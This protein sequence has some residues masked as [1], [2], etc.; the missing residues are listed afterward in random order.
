MNND[1]DE[2]EDPLDAFMAGIENQVNV[3][4]FHLRCLR[5]DSHIF[6]ICAGEE[7]NHWCSE[8]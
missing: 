5:A 3:R 7:R 2:D 6:I 4:Y 8:K 1:T